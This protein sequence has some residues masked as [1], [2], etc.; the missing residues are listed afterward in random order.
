MPD[1]SE[2][3]IRACNWRVDGYCSRPFIQRLREA[4]ANILPGGVR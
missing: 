3:T 2:T 1:R 4:A